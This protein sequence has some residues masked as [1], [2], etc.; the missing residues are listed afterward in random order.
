MTELRYLKGDAT[1]PVGDDV[2]IICH[3][4]NNEG[5]WGSCFV[6][7]V[8]RKWGGPESIFRTSYRKG[9]DSSLGDVQGVQ[10]N[11]LTYVQ[12][13]IAQNGI[14]SNSNPK[15]I[16]YEALCKCM[17]EVVKGMRNLEELW[18]FSRS[19]SIH[20]PRFGSGLSQGNWAF[21]EE[22]IKEIWVDA[23]IDVYIYEFE[24]K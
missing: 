24:K 11:D 22:L 18:G 17:R 12:N 8:S 6:V 2:K 4:C 1:E 23:G 10:V 9:I 19:F 20:A 3:I 13:M 7:A 16:K 15:P 21:I 14:V 5:R